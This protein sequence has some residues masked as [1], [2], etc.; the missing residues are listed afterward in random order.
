VQSTTWSSR[1]SVACAALQIGVIATNRQ[2]LRLPSRRRY[3]Q[4]HAVGC[5]CCRKQ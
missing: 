4:W 2:L 1:S 3:Q 5:M